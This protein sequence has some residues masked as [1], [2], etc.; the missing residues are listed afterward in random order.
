MRRK[1][2]ARMVNEVVA[3]LKRLLSSEG[4]QLVHEGRY[5]RFLQRAEEAANKGAGLPANHLVFEAHEVCQ[6]L[7]DEILKKSSGR[8]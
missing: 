5:Q 7:C 6:L 8:R 1:K 4:L 3:S 2:K